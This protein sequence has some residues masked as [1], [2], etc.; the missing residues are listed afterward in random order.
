[1]LHR[2]DAEWSEAQDT[3]NIICTSHDLYLDARA[4]LSEVILMLHPDCKSCNR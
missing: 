4:G 2:D 3:Q 1:M